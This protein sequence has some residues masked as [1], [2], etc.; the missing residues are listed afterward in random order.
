MSMNHFICCYK[1]HVCNIFFFL[2]H[3]HALYIHNH[4]QMYIL[5]FHLL[6]W[7]RTELLWFLV[8][9]LV[10]PFPLIF[11]QCLHITGGKGDS[12]LHPMKHLTVT[13][14]M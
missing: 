10:I 8:K 3:I 9:D 2:T 4:V 11:L 7:R 13:Q 1:V 5:N 6:L 12:G 14:V